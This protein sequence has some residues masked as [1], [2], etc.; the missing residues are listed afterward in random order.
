MAIKQ[1]IIL[2]K[3]NNPGNEFN[4]NEHLYSKMFIDYMF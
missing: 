4:L 2:M 1:Q 3:W